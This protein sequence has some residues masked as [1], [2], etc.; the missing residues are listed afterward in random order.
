MDGSSTQQS[1]KKE[2]RPQVAIDHVAKIAKS[3]SAPVDL[4]ARMLTMTDGTVKVVRQILEADV[5]RARAFGWVV[6]SVGT[7]LTIGAAGV[8]VFT[9]HAS[10]ATEERY[11]RRL[12]EEGNRRLSLEGDLA[13]QKALTEA[14][15]EREERDRDARKAIQTRLSETLGLLEMAQD[16][17]AHTHRNASRIADEE[18]LTRKF[19]TRAEHQQTREVLYSMLRNLSAVLDRSK[20]ATTGNAHSGLGRTPC[21][22]PTLAARD[23]A[24]PPVASVTL[25]ALRHS[26]IPSILPDCDTKTHECY[27]NSSGICTVP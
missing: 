14:S 17:L 9:A 18:R 4:H 7:A 24:E 10:R 13:L 27:A 23:A 8:A 6:C 12:V 19:V 25:V 2:D 22:E 20:F 3:E 26:A 1:Y 15:R 16:E 11:Q 21:D 5:R